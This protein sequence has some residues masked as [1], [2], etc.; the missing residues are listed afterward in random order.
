MNTKSTEATSNLK[1]LLS[2]FERLNSEHIR[3]EKM[4]SVLSDEE[5]RLIK[6][7][8]LDNPADFEKISQIRMRRDLVPLKAREFAA[9]AKTDAE[10]LKHL[11]I[12]ISRDHL[13]DLEVKFEATVAKLTK[14]LSQVF[15]AEQ[16]ADDATRI[17]R[18]NTL[19]DQWDARDA[20]EAITCQTRIGRILDEQRKFILTNYNAWTSN[21]PAVLAK[22]LLEFIDTVDAIR[23]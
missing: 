11:C 14:A 19:G 9:A 15:P 17:I 12:A 20:A 16:A 8:N 23:I 4:A 21:D 22:Q 2:E 3:H 18:R 1:R 7:A 6:S 13:K 5:N 10:K